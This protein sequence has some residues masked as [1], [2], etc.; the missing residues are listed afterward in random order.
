[1]V[2]F[3]KS[4]V[5]IVDDHPVIRMALSSLLSTNG[6]EVAGEADNGV[7]AIQL[8]K[9]V[10]PAVV[11]LDISIPRL[12]GMTVISRV[13]SLPEPPDIL[14]FTSM[15]TQV[16]SRRC[17]QAGASGFVNKE[18][19]M[20]AVL[21]GIRSILDGYQYFPKDAKVSSD[22]EGSGDDGELIRSLSERELVVFSQ[23]AQGRSNKEISDQ[24]L[25][26]NKTVSTYKTRVY[27]KLGVSNVA[28]LIELA[29]RNAI[30]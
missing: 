24:L 22:G 30:I 28:E 11:V 2:S 4:S 27:Q 21:N 13:R 16:Y 6:L 14:V 25:I 17:W 5:V 1:M 7:D 15:A 23:I 20:T 3:A 10:K 29:K 9:Q 12:D 26:S 18:Q 8:V 19:N